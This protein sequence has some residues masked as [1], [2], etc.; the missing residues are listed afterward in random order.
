LALSGAVLNG[1]SL[2]HLLTPEGF[3]TPGYVVVDPATGRA[4]VSNM[5]TPPETYRADPSTGKIP[6][7]DATGQ[8]RH[9]T[10]ARI[11]CVNGITL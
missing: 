6:R 5:A 1:Q 8:G 10:V 11:E 2:P 9:E 3:A 4:D 7:L